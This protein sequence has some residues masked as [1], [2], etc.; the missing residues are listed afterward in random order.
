MEGMS[1]YL[2]AADMPYSIEVL[3]R[4]NSRSFNSHH[5]SIF[6]LTPLVHLS[7]HTTGPSFNSHHWSI[8]Q[9]T[10]LVHLNGVIKLLDM[11]ALL[12]KTP[13]SMWTRRDPSLPTAKTRPETR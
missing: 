10:P 1:S 11:S 6:Q 2:P 5:W 4:A 3:V 12:S 9:L 13:F 8:F 7:T